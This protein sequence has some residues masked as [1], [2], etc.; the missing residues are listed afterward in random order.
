MTH[1]CCQRSTRP[2][3]RGIRHLMRPNSPLLGIALSVCTLAGAGSPSAPLSADVRF[4]HMLV[5]VGPQNPQMMR[6]YYYRLF[7]PNGVRL[8]EVNGTFGV[9]SGET[10]LLISGERPAS[11]DQP[12]AL[13]H[14]GWG[15]LSLNETYAQHYFKEIE[16]K[17]PRV[18]LLDRFHLHLNSADPRRA[19]EWYALALGAETLLG[20]QSDSSE[21]P[22]DAGRPAEAFAKLGDVTLSFYRTSADLVCSRGQRVDHLAVVADLSTIE[23]APQVSSRCGQIAAP[24]EFGPAVAIEGPDGLVIEVIAG[25]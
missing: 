19:A 8:E 15:S 5:R 16:W 9:A 18:S 2:T 4:H 6:D 20:T 1:D 12:F 24:D 22:D 21:G 11:P 3:S 10:H 13:W 23:K 25:E 17:D 14:F 7:D